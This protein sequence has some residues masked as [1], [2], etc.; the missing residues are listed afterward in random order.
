MCRESTLVRWS[1]DGTEPAA[2]RLLIILQVSSLACFLTM[3]TCIE[4]GS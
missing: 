2:P 3:D 4:V 1:T